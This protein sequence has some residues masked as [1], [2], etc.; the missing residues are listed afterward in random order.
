MRTLAVAA[1]GLMILA[2]NA[3]AQPAT[4]LKYKFVEGTS[5][6]YADTVDVQM[7]Q[8]M[9]GQ[10]MKMSQHIAAVTRYAVESVTAEGGAKLIATNDTMQIKIKN[11]RMDTTMVPVELLHR[12]NRLTITSLG[13]ITGRE[14]IDSIKATALMRGSGGLG[15]REILRLPV[16]SAK[17][18]K[19]GDS[20]TNT[21][22]D[23]SKSDGGSSVLSSTM[24]YKMVGTEKYAGRTCV[25][26]SYTGKLGVNSKGTMGGMEVFTEGTGTVTGVAYF[27]TKSGVFVGDEGKTEMEMTAAVTGQQNMTIPISQTTKSKHILLP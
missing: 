6:R 17:P 25:K 16:L 27:D 13:D 20:W 7:T 2:G 14:V 21:K 15:S 11:P 18:V 4:A 5:I 9:M 8:E 22:V 26:L 19:V 1:V 12:R 3:G 10:E 23:S 24:E